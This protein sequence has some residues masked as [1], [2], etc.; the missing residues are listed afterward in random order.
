MMKEKE[1][2]EE[3][4]DRQPEGVLVARTSAM[5]RDANPNGDIFGGWIMS[6]MDMGGGLMAREVARGRIT[7]VTVDKMTFLRPVLVGDTIC[8][9]ANVVRIGNSSMDIKLEVWAK[10]LLDEFWSQRHLVT[11]GLFRYV[12]IDEK[13]RPRRVPD[14]PLF[15]RSQA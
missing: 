15:P 3:K 9:Y 6:Q 13:G 5:P 10:G 1:V 11:E 4:Q 8:V 7:T 2:S 12:A 14:N